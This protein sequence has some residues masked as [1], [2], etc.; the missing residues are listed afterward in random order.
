MMFY[1]LCE[2][3]LHEVLS[4]W[5]PEFVF[6]A[7]SDELFFSTAGETA[8]DVEGEAEAGLAAPA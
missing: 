7:V 4:I 6:T 2:W 3:H 8:G 5:T 1:A